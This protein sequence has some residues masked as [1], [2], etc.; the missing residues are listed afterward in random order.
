MY[1]QYVESQQHPNAPD[2][3]YQ[4]TAVWTGNDMIVWGGGSNAGVFNTGGR[5]SP[6]PMVG[7][8]PVR[9]ARPMLENFTRQCGLVLK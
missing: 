4:H 7:R 2:G 3:R 9:R 1:R 6:S 5:Y 8:P